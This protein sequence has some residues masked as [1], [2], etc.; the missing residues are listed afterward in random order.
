MKKGTSRPAWGGMSSVNP[1][2]TQSMKSSSTRA[3]LVSETANTR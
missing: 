1:E 2:P 3:L